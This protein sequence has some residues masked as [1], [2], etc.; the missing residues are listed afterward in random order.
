MRVEIRGG[1]H[2]FSLTVKLRCNPPTEI[3]SPRL[4]NACAYTVEIDIAVHPNILSLDLSSWQARCLCVHVWPRFA[5]PTVDTQM[6][7]P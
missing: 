4:E 6:S 7:A 1:H 2:R 3:P 5:F